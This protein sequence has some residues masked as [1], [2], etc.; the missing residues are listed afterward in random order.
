MQSNYKGFDFGIWI[1]CLAFG[2]N[3]CVCLRAWKVCESKR[4]CFSFKIESC[5]FWTH[6]VVVSGCVNC[7]QYFNHIIL[8]CI[9]LSPLI[10]VDSIK[11]ATVDCQGLAIISKRQD[12][13]LKI[14][15]LFYH[16]FLRY[17]LYSRIWS[18]CWSNVG[19]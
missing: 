7:F 9:Y 2:F 17:T 19:L 14:K 18:T 15:R 12:V 8:V 3:F 11:I 16:L 6:L 4:D 1:Q 10:M 13:L 5:V